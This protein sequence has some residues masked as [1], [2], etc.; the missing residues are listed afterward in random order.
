[1]L[2]QTGEVSPKNVVF[3][4]CQELQVNSP[5]KR[6]LSSKVKFKLLV[7]GVNTAGKNTF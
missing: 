4:C 5:V 3:N 7:A 6:Q 2:R 1:M